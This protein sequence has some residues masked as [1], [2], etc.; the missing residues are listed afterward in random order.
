MTAGSELNISLLISDN[1]T[2][3]AKRFEKIQSRLVPDVGTA[4]LS[5]KS[6][7]LQPVASRV[8]LCFVSEWAALVGR[9]KTQTI[10]STWAEGF[11]YSETIESLVG[12]HT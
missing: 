8:R 3:S 7:S 1:T 5:K 12:A 9:L 11:S 10:G 4:S 6:H 2:I